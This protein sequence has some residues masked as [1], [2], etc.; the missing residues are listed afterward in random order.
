MKF[1]FENRFRGSKVTN[2]AMLLVMMFV[3]WMVNA[4]V[5]AQVAC[6]GEDAM[7]AMSEASNLKTWNDVFDSY[8]KYKQCDDGATAEGY[9]A[10]VAYLLADKWQDVGE[11][12]KLS[13]KNAGFRQFVLKH[14]DV[15]MSMEQS[16]DIKRNVKDHCPASAKKICVDIQRR[17]VE[18]G[19]Q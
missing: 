12:L 13:E 5:M 16:V 10:S 8:R 7:K 19:S 4:S 3:L 15:T 6:A 17:L 2:A 14:V 11:L 18:F 9:S 1:F